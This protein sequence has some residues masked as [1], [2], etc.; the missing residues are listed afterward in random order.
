MKDKILVSIIIPTYQNSLNLIDIPL[1]SIYKQTCSKN[2]YEVII[3]N[4]YWAK[5]FL[6]KKKIQKFKINT[7]F[8]EVYGKPPQV[9]NQVNVG[10]K[11][12]KGKYILILDHDVELSSKLIESFSNLEKKFSEIDSWYMPYKV[13]AKGMLNKIRN[14][15][16]KFYQH[17]VVAVPRIIKK[18]IFFKTERQYDPILS[19]GPADWDITNQLIEASA[20]FKYIDEYAYHH[21]ERLG[22]WGFIT[23]KR[24][25][26]EGLELYKRKWA[27]KNRKIYNQIVKKQFSPFYRLVGIFIED[28]KWKKTFKSFPI[29]ILFLIMKILVAGNFWINKNFN[30]NYAK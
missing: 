16:E 19:G 23:K 15:E 17:S 24:I 20:I 21:E 8:I 3:S 5:G 7:K 25:Y 11:A 2:L 30:N 14:F 1:E 6:L 29:Y 27:K 22:F 9:C 26:T 28:G 10:A 13:V 4:N 18:S 12:A